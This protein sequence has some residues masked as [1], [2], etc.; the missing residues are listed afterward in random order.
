VALPG[1][2][3]WVNVRRPYPPLR[4]W[5]T[6][7]IVKLSAAA[8]VGA[9]VALLVDSDMEF[10]RTFG[11]EQF[12]RDGV[13]RFYR[14]ADAI[15]EQNLPRHVRWHQ[16][17]RRL[18]GLPPAE[19]P[20]ADYICW[21][22]PWDPAVVRALQARVEEVTGKPWATAIGAEL[23]FSE[24]ILYGVFV[25]EVLDARAKSYTVDEMLCPEYSEEVP[26]DRVGLDAF[27]SVIS[28]ADIA[29]M[30]SAKSQ[31]P[32]DVRRQAIAALTSS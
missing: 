8:R 20:F 2:N 13:V 12:L 31:T 24:M 14:K 3:G 6:Q 16:V 32:L 4:G 9:D 19:P 30:V 11:P 26:L 29:V 7:Q 5:I 1:V 22:A 15:T 18:L 28:P 27:L 10:V 21:P 25:D 23:H 17:S